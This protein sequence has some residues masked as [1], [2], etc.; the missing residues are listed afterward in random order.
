[1]LREVTQMDVVEL[2]ERGYGCGRCRF[3]GRMVTWVVC[4]VWMRAVRLW[5]G[6]R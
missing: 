2:H 3:G 5:G 6:R 4:P 1:M